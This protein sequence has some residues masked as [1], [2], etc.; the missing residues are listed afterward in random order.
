[1][2]AGHRRFEIGTCASGVKAAY[3]APCQALAADFPTLIFISLSLP[4]FSHFKLHVSI[5]HIHF[6]RPD[7]G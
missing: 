2:R 1:M 5:F 6:A 4:F 3:F 7:L